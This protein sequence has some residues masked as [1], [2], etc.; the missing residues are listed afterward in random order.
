MLTSSQALF[1]QSK[2]VQIKGNPYKSSRDKKR[3]VPRYKFIDLE[4]EIHTS[5]FPHFAKIAEG[6]KKQASKDFAK[7]LYEGDRIVTLRICCTFKHD[8]K[9]PHFGKFETAVSLAGREA[10]KR[11]AKEKSAE[12]PK[13]SGK[14]TILT[15][16]RSDRQR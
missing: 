8:L 3:Q 4:L 13:A 15:R 7:L 14:Y 11:L 2:G 5:K 12:L 9:T 6:L 16:Y 1:W 10:E